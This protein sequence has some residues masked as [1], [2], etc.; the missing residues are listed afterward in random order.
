MKAPDIL[1][2]YFFVLP[3]LFRVFAVLG[4]RK[5]KKKN[6]LKIPFEA[7]ILIFFFFLPGNPTVRV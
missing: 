4:L 6:K 1:F 5:K 7:E 3:E 2:W